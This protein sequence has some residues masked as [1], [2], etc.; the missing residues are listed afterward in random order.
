MSGI[1]GKTAM[2]A[3]QAEVSE[4]YIDLLRELERK[5]R[6]WVGAT[7]R[8]EFIPFYLPMRLQERN[9]EYASK[10][11]NMS[12]KIR[13]H[14]GKLRV[15]ISVV[16]SWFQEPVDSIIKQIGVILAEPNGK[17]VETIFLL[18]GFGACRLLQESLKKRFSDKQVIVPK[19]PELAILKGAVM[20]GHKCVGKRI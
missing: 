20:L 15:H 2:E 10:T 17:G 6:S 4:D 11:L 18:G 14:P 19:D 8:H 5:K 7:E 12:D 1:F 13:V 3:F 16:E 9:T